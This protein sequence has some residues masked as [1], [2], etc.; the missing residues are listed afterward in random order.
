LEIPDNV[1]IVARKD[2]KLLYKSS[3]LDIK[4]CLARLVK[5]GILDAD[6][7]KYS[8]KRQGDYTTITLSNG[9]VIYAMQTKN[10]FEGLGAS[11]GFF[12]IDDA[13]ESREEIFIGDETNAGLISRLRLPH[14]AYWQSPSGETVNRLHGMLSTNPPPLNH[15]LHKLFGKT[16]GVRMIGDDAYEFM[17]VETFLN[18]FVGDSYAKGL[19]AVQAKMGRSSDNARRIIFGESLVAYGGIRVYPQ[20]QPELHVGHYTFDAQLP[21]VRSWDFGFHHPAIIFSNLYKCQ[22][23]Y[24]HLRSLSEVSQLFSCDVWQL[25]TE[26]IRHHKERYSDAKLVLDAGDRSGYRGSATN[27]DRRGEIKILKAEYGLEF[28]FGFFDVKNSLEYMRGL[29]KTK[30]KC[31]EQLIQINVDCEVLIEGLTGGYKYPKSRDGVIGDKPVKDKYYDDVADA[32]R[33]GAE[34]YVKWEIPFDIARPFTPKVQ[35]TRN[36][37]PWAWMEISDNDPE[38]VLTG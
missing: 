9:S 37:K 20:F 12:W 32:W 24:N 18:P 34:N 11:Y 1:G 28:K 13:M 27:R 3:W 23:G 14:V 16:A 10:I 5:K 38:R 35:G 33:Y 2:F 8:D 15:W 29:L 36:N 22:H 26:M 30:C 7:I 17:Q 4:N 21:L 25:Y 6:D 19:M 31:G